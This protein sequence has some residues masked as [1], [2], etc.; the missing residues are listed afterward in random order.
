MS[1]EYF[2]ICSQVLVLFVTNALWLTLMLELGRRQTNSIEIF[3]TNPLGFVFL[4][5]Y[6]FLFLL[7]FLCTLWHR[8]GTAIQ[9]LTATPF[10]P[11][12]NDHW[13]QKAGSSEQ[14][15]QNPNP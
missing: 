13:Y 12:R 7:Q 1:N 11:H 6:G 8:L 2:L 10:P 14:H 15:L 5:V 4:I 3:G 9:I